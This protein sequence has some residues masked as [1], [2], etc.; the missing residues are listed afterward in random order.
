MNYIHILF[1]GKK[2]QPSFRQPSKVV[3]QWLCNETADGVCLSGIFILILLRLVLYFE[4]G[5][6]LVDGRKKGQLTRLGRIPVLS[7]SGADNSCGK[8]ISVRGGLFLDTRGVLLA[9]QEATNSFVSQSNRYQT[10]RKLKSNQLGIAN[11]I[12]DELC[13]SVDFFLFQWFSSKVF[14]LHKSILIFR[15]V[16]SRHW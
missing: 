2:N 14:P 8:E 10:T 16:H 11:E 4:I 5:W 9:P 3:A 6:T 13:R 7:A 12:F 15:W 1:K